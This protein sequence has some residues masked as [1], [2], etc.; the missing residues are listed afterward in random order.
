VTERKFVEHLPDLITPDEYEADPEGR[1]IKIRIR[2]TADGVEV[3]G[4]AVRPKALE[5]LL[6][7]LSPEAIEQMLCG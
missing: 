2:P 3:L 1:T 6:L 4:D 7:A 5:D